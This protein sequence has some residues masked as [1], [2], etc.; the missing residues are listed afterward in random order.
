MQPLRPSRLRLD[1]LEGFVERRI[2]NAAS[3][4]WVEAQSVPECELDEGERD[5][6]LARL[7]RTLP[8]CRE[9]DHFPAPQ[10][11]RWDDIE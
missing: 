10:R 6:P 3:A 1:S 9:R 2:G 11:G 7:A 5:D 4:R 8:L